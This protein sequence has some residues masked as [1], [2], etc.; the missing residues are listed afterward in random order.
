MPATQIKIRLQAKLIKNKQ[1]LVN[2]NKGPK[3]YCKEFEKSGVL[4]RGF[5]TSCRV[6]KRAKRLKD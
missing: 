6:Y 4:N 1:T 3:K 2:K 5:K